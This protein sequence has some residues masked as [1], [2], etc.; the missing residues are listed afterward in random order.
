M[1]LRISSLASCTRVGPDDAYA[2]R[3]AQTLPHAAPETWTALE[4]VV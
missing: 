2:M 1:V 3:D 4:D